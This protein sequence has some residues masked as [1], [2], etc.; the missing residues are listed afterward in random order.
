MTDEAKFALYSEIMENAPSLGLRRHQTVWEIDDHIVFH[1]AF[2]NYLNCADEGKYELFLKQRY[3]HVDAAL[4]EKYKNFPPI[5]PLADED[6]EDLADE[7]IEEDPYLKAVDLALEEKY[8]NFHPINPLADEDIE[9]EDPYIQAVDLDHKHYE[10][11]HTEYDQLCDQKN[12]VTFPLS[13][14]DLLQNREQ[15]SD[16]SHLTMADPYHTH[17]YDYDCDCDTISIEAP[18]SILPPKDF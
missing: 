12:H 8:K 3:A 17:F 6:I 5:N 2:G 11:T 16:I 14:T 1:I 18:L 4:E 13:A 7:D 9:E 10:Y 15:I